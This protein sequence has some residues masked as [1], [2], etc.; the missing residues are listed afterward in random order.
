[1]TGAHCS[2]PDG[3]LGPLTVSPRCL[4]DDEPFR[5]SLRSFSVAPTY[6][7]APAYTG[8]LK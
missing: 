8:W 3:P 1:M 6:S 7:L 5:S 2:K 4:P